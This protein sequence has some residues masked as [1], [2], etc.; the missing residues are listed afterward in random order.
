MEGEFARALEGAQAGYDV[1]HLYYGHCSKEYIRLHK[2]W[3]GSMP[4]SFSALKLLSEKNAIR[5]ERDTWTLTQRL[6]DCRKSTFDELSEDLIPGYNTNVRDL[7]KLLI[8][9]NQ[10]LQE[11]TLGTL[12]IFFSNIKVLEWLE[13]IANASGDV[14][15]VERDG[16]SQSMYGLEDE[17]TL[18]KLD[19]NS[20]DLDPQATQD[21][22]KAIWQK[23]R[24]GLYVCTILLL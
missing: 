20:N 4:E 1:L 9:H 2:A 6:L 5:L 19:G 11:E 24:K 13:E 7:A 18:Q 23:L 14:A 15:E 8:E 21:I 12:L 22:C 16:A 3:E 10:D 17:A